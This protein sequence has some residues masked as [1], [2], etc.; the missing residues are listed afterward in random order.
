MHPARLLA[1]LASAA[2]IAGAAPASASPAASPYIVVL[3]P[4]ALTCEEAIAT[5]TT[6][7]GLKTR[8]SYKDALCG[9]ATQLTPEERTAVASDPL[10]AY[11]QADSRVT[12]GV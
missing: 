1:L 7:S 10:V 12:G 3:N 6:T 4:G 5:V 9:F 8:S 11:V 2:L